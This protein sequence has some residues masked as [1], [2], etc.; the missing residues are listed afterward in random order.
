MLAS[1]SQCALNSPLL[2]QDVFDFEGSMRRTD[3]C[4]SLD[5]HNYKYTEEEKT[6]R[7]NSE[8]VATKHSTSHPST[9]SYSTGLVTPSIS[10]DY[11]FR[12]IKEGRPA[13]AG[14]FHSGSRFRSS[15]SLGSAPEPTRH[16]SPQIHQTTATRHQSFDANHPRMLR[17]TS[18]TKYPSQ[19][20]KMS[21][22]DVLPNRGDMIAPAE[23]LAMYRSVSTFRCESLV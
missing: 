22:H 7:R 4:G 21:C 8:S 23:R 18:P 19:N 12:P 17:S 2:A 14:E 1:K 5:S 15:T 3:S 11:I 16:P 13:T 9:S 10:T 20:F 6:T